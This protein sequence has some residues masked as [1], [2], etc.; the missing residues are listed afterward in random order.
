M[1]QLD[2]ATQPCQGLHHKLLHL[3]WLHCLPLCQTKLR[4]LTSVQGQ[5]GKWAGKLSHLLDQFHLLM[6][7]LIQWLPIVAEVR[8]RGMRI[9]LFL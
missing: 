8:D 4:F 7:G 1:P 3:T 6:L 9:A 2:K 5:E